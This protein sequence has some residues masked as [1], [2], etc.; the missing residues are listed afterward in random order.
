MPMATKNEI[1]VSVGRVCT[2]DDLS[3]A[4]VCASENFVQYDASFLLSFKHFDYRITHTCMTVI[5][6]VANDISKNY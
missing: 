5:Y 4:T 3:W 6:T 1:N 2:Q